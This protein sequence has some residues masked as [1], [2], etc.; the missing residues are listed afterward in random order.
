MHQKDAVPKLMEFLEGLSG[1][2]IELRAE[3]E[4]EE[5]E[6]QVDL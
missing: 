2:T 3:E 4:E 6:E 5:E 1:T